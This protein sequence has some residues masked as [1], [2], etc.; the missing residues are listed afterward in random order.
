MWLRASLG[1]AERHPGL[2]EQSAQHPH[3]NLHSSLQGKGSVLQKACF[4]FHEPLIRAAMW[5]AEFLE[6]NR[7]EAKE[8]SQLRWR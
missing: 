3:C 7:R 6:V 1:D 2:S 5:L 4:A 8:R